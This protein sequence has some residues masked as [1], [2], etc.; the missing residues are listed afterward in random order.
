MLV[1]KEVLQAVVKEKGSVEVSWLGKELG[2]GRNTLF[3]LLK[4][5]G[6]VNWQLPMPSDFA[7]EHGYLVKGMK[8]CRVPR[9]KN[10]KF[11]TTEV[12]EEGVEV[13]LSNLPELIDTVEDESYK[14]KI[15]YRLCNAGLI[16][17]VSTK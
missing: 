15:I 10:V 2:L 7:T 8:F 14:A 1:S 11:Y 13:L 12:T 17:S 3:Y 9:F 6:W 5:A 16:D 4:C